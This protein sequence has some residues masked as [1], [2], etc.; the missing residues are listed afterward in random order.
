MAAA[1][2]Y[3]PYQDSKLV[4]FASNYDSIITA[5]PTVVGLT[6]PQ[7][8]ANHN[9]TLD[10]IAKNATAVNPATRNKGSIIA[11]NESRKALVASIRFL[12][13][14][15]Q[16]YPGTTDQM[17]ADLGITVPD[18]EI[19]PINPPD[20]APTINVLSVVGHTIKVKLTEGNSTRRGLPVNVTGA[21]IFTHVGENAPQNI[22]DWKFEGLVSRHIAEVEISSDVPAG[23]KIWL[24]GFFF[25]NR[26]QSGPGA[27]PIATYIGG[28]MSLAA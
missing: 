22:N 11:K 4:E 14:I 23:S 21:S 1:K 26:K 5:A 27:S 17:R 8:L 24:T 18:S 28:G 3:I 10:F 9:L 25:N 12:T 19:S 2:N 13:K 16:A 7:T 20:F 6:A 15:I